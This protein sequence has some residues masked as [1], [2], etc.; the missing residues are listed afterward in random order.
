MALRTTTARTRSR[1]DRLMLQTIAGAA[2]VLGVLGPARSVEAQTPTD[3]TGTPHAELVLRYTPN[4]VDVPTGI[5]VAL[6]ITVLNNGPAPAP[7]TVVRVGIR[8][9]GGGDGSRF[10]FLDSG[11]APLSDDARTITWRAGLLAVNESATLHTKIESDLPT[12]GNDELNLH[13]NS[14]N[15]PDP[16]VTGEGPHC[17][18]FAGF[19]NATGAPI[20]APA[21]VAPT[22]RTTTSGPAAPSTSATATTS[23][24]GT[25]S[26]SSTRAGTT[27]TSGSS[28]SNA[29]PIAIGV[30]AAAGLGSVGALRWKAR[31]S[32]QNT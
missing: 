2:L 26:S 13:A 32:R 4:P 29:V 21:T 7:N 12:P 17:C 16:L 27:K 19:L 30:A 11:G 25:S 10:R 3:S 5:I 1:G 28:G 15:T 6:D 22:I 8:L 9:F 14:D 18:G 23:V 31:R 24:A 20:T